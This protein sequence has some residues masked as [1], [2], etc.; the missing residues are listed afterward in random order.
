[1]IQGGVR[2]APDDR[3]LL[4]RA[5]YAL[6]A[7]LAALTSRA[8]DGSGDPLSHANVARDDLVRDLIPAKAVA[9]LV[10]LPGQGKSFLAIEL[11]ARVAKHPREEEITGQP[12]PERF[13]DREV[14][15]GTVLYFTSEDADGVRRRIARWEAVNGPLPN[16]HLFGRVPPLS[17]LNRAIP[18]VLEALDKSHAEGAPPLRLIVIDVVR[19]AV[20]GDENSSDI[21]GP[22]MVRRIG[23]RSV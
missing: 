20:E 4:R 8:N 19:A 6:L 12:E 16:L 23:T 22:A 18:F 7:N 14:Q 3:G 17:A 2:S 10:G 15:H 21:M 13:A 11:A 1:M 5:A 9:A